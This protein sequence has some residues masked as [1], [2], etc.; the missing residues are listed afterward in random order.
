MPTID[1]FPTLGERSSTPQ[2]VQYQ[3]GAWSN[4][5]LRGI[6]SSSEFPALTGAASNV[7]NTNIGQTRGIWREQ[8]AAS[9]SST[10]QNT[11]PKKVPQPVKPVTNGVASMT[12]KEDFPALKRAH[13]TTIPAP[14]STFSA[15][16]TAKKSAKSASGK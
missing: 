8:Q 7:S 15:W 5:P 11:I 9:I 13:N 6:H 16:S 12:M 14:V 2:N 10:T 4:D 3:R 1:E